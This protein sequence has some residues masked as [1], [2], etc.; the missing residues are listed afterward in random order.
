[1]HNEKR[2]WFKYFSNILRL[3]LYWVLDW[4]WLAD[5]F[6]EDFFFSYVILGIWVLKANICI[7]LLHFRKI[8][9]YIGGNIC[10][11]NC[12]D[13]FIYPPCKYYVGCFNPICYFQ[14]LTLPSKKYHVPNS[15]P[16][17]LRDIKFQLKVGNIIPIS[18][19]FFFLYLSICLINQAWNII[20]RFWYY[21]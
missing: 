9:L 18:I 4:E 14:D 15:R 19:H 11:N 8:L 17:R 1:M 3:L 21:F 13:I 20:L 16:S 12:F 2:S 10:N 5:R 7:L 6:Y